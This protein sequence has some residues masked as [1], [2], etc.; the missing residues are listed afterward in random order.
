M[1]QLEELRLHLKLAKYELAK[2]IGITQQT[3]TNYITGRREMLLSV[4]K[5][6]SLKYDISLDW[7]LLGRGMMFLSEIERRLKKSND[8][9]KLLQTVEDTNSKVIEI[10]NL[11]ANDE[12]E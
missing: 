12:S 7:L 4:A 10:Y 9:E 6:I 8:G 1:L 2:E 3:Y 11:L 5:E